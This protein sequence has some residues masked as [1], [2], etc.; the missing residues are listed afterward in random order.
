MSDINPIN[1]DTSGDSAPAR[2]AIMDRLDCIPGV[3]ARM[4][5][6]FRMLLAYSGNCHMINP[7]VKTT[8]DKTLNAKDA[9]ARFV[10]VSTISIIIIS[11][12]EFC[13]CLLLYK[14]V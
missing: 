2:V 8:K 9:A 5:I 6:M 12:R 10:F 3:S 4:F 7:N 1:K 14:Y 13:V 11:H